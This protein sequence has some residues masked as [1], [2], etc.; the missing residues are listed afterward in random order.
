MFSTTLWKRVLL[1]FNYHLL[2]GVKRVTEWSQCLKCVLK[3]LHC[4]GGNG[5]KTDLVAKLRN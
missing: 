4:F 5:S 1:H 3:A 2:V